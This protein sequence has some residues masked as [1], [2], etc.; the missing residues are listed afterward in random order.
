MASNKPWAVRMA[1]NK[2]WAVRMA[3]N[4]ML[5]ACRFKNKC[6]HPVG[7]QSKFENLSCNSAPNMV[8]GVA[9]KYS[10]TLTISW[11]RTWF[12]LLLSLRLPLNGLRIMRRLFGLLVG[13]LMILRR[14]I[15]DMRHLV[16][17]M[18]SIIGLWYLL[19][20]GSTRVRLA[21][22]LNGG[23]IRYWS[24]LT[25]TIYNVPAGCQGRTREQPHWVFPGG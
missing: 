17:C 23:L 21:V 15:S 19:W 13:F 1:A 12:R 20:T 6:E 4:K 8:L 10:G 11:W 5:V 2:P 3:A 9:L 14:G 18:I 16:V 24:V 25:E 22:C 7:M